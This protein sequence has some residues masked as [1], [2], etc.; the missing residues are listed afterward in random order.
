MI[1]L[2]TTTL[3]WLFDSLT[4]D[5]KNGQGHQEKVWSIKENVLLFQVVVILICF[6]K[7][8]SV[9]IIERHFKILGRPNSR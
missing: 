7:I 9:S 1:Y 5:P 3:Q 6:V 2:S 8:P 4:N